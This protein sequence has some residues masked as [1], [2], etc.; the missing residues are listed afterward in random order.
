M[1]SSRSISIAIFFLALLIRLAYV[2]LAPRIDPLLKGEGE[3]RHDAMSY[4]AIG[5]SLATGQGYTH[6]AA[7]VN[8]D[9]RPPLY[10]FMLASIYKMFGHSLL[11]VRLVQAILG[12]LTCLLLSLIGTRLA[13]AP[14]GWLAGLGLAFHPLY[15][16]FTAWI[17]IE[18]L[19]IFLFV[20]ALFLWVGLGRKP[21]WKGTLALGLVWGIAALA[22]PIFVIAPILFLVWGL[23]FIRPKLKA[24]GLT[25]L[26]VVCI[27]AVQAPWLAYQS[28]SREQVE[29]TA[30]G[31]DRPVFVFL[32][33]LNNSYADG[34]EQTDLSLL[35]SDLAAWEALSPSQQNQKALRSVLDWILTRPHE[36]LLNCGKRLVKFF[37]PFEFGTDPSR[38]GAK[39][40]LPMSIQVP[41]LV[42]YG[43]Y[44]A[45]ALIGLIASL[46]CW[47][48][49]LPLYLT[50]GYFL[51]FHGLIWASSTRYSMPAMSIVI[52]W[53]ARGAIWLFDR[54]RSG[55]LGG[56]IHSK[57]SH[58]S[59]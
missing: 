54:L 5:W 17:Y 50:F 32:W 23:M 36:Y 7:Y 39:F 15:L 57:V 12:A 19:Y 1:R 45:I 46:N 37:S 42:A 24:I 38:R 34:G 35:V 8:V 9:M 30:S 25:L 48:E 41:V 6:P 49:F 10:P 56:R 53:A 52:I 43:I 11:A 2:P 3:L 27:C 13:S 16:S 14:V 55:R 33:Q 18:T 29:L 59:R 21:T 4:D 44:L 31:I 40:P 20:L 47:R 28:A 58:T 51:A 22:R 26:L